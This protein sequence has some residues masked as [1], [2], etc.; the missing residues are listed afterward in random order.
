MTA[1]LENLS[2]T[3]ERVALQKDSFSDKQNP[4]TVF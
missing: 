1:G 4:K 3:V 2:M